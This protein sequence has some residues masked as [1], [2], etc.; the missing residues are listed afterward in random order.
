LF[1]RQEREKFKR[2]RCFTAV[3]LLPLASNDREESDGGGG[4]EEERRNSFVEALN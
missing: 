2:E 3:C 4:G 1:L